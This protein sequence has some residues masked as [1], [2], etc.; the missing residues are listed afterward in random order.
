MSTPAAAQPLPSLS[1]FALCQLDRLN[2]HVALRTPLP[3]WAGAG[4]RLELFVYALLALAGA[5]CVAAWNPDWY[6]A[7]SYV[8][9]GKIALKCLTYLAAARACLLVERRA[10][11]TMLFACVNLGAIAMFFDPREGRRRVVFFFAAYLAMAAWHFLMLRLFAEREGAWPWL[12]FFSPIAALVVVRYTPFLIEPLWKAIPGLSIASP[13][14]FFVGLSYM[15]FRLSYLALEVRNRITPRPDFWEYLGFA[16]FL[17][18]LVVGPIN[19]YSAHRQ[20]IEHPDRAVTPVGRSCLRILIGFTK[21]QFLGNVFNQLSYAGL[22]LDGHPHAP[23]DVFVAAVCY[24]L[25]LYCN[26]AGFCDM[27][28]GAAGLLGIHV[29]E[30]FRN[31]LTARSVKE[32]WTRWHITL[33]TYFRDVVFSPLSKFF[34][35]RLGM[36]RAHHAIALAIVVV[37]LLVGVWHG[38]GWR[39]AIYGALHAAGVATNHYYTIWLKRRLGKDRFKAYQ[40]NRWIT[41]AAVT[42][43]F[44]FVTASLFF[45]ANDFPAMEKIFLAIR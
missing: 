34:I 11:Q 6:R 36:R 15:A 3:S 31:P 18:T 5:A 35:D 1:L 38:A 21:Y 14:A 24:H 42:A 33:S 9:V 44:F 22:L 4:R 17:P 13:A 40:E 10:L 19:P 2:Q 12:A 43:T 26:F 37:F 16:F 8:H 20:S 23:L 45:F 30:N 28:I 29:K 25:Y 41:A 39:F 32:Y 27:A 7:L